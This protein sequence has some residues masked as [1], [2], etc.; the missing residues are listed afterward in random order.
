MQIPRKL[1]VVCR[2]GLSRFLTKSLIVGAYGLLGF[3]ILGCGPTTRQINIPP[4]DDAEL[5]T[6]LVTG[7][8]EVTQLP[9]GWRDSWFSY[10]S[11]EVFIEN[12][13][14][15][16]FMFAHIMNEDQQAFFFWYLPP[17]KYAIESFH[18]SSGINIGISQG[19]KQLSGRI[20]AIFTVPEAAQAVYIGSLVMNPMRNSNDGIIRDLKILDEF[21]Q[22]K[23]AYTKR[24]QSSVKTWDK[25]LMTWRPR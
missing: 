11:M 4:P 16:D 19:S 20:R 14:N 9:R 8:I 7:Q 3:Q 15:H 6:V 12:A 24:Y 21:D 22:A 1:L 5:G 25:S 2:K 23:A 17:G 13:D 18:W 10:N